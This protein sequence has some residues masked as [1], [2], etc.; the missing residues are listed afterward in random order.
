MRRTSAC[1]DGSLQLCSL[2]ANF[3]NPKARCRWLAFLV[4]ELHLTGSNL[5]PGG[6]A[7]LPPLCS[8][9]VLCE[10]LLADGGPTRSGALCCHQKTCFV[11]KKPCAQA[12][13]YLSAC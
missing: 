10:R 12:R 7:Y 9:A 2:A 8:S 11:T 3:R 1:G 6:T 4:L 13:A 5:V